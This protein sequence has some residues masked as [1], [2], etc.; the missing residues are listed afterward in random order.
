MSKFSPRPITLYTIPVPD[1]TR[2]LHVEQVALH[3]ESSAVDIGALCFLSRSPKKRAKGKGREV[4]LDSFEPAR[5][6]SIHRIAECFL[7]QSTLKEISPLTVSARCLALIQ[8][9]DWCDENGHSKALDELRFGREAF[10]G[11]AQY[12]RHLFEV[13]GRQ[14]RTIYTWQRNVIYVLNQHFDVTNIELGANAI[15]WDDRL[16][17]RTEAPTSIRFSKFVSLIQAVFTGIAELILENRPFPHAVKMPVFVGY[18]DNNMWMFPNVAGWVRHPSSDETKNAA[19]DYFRGR[20]RPVDEVAHL[21][22]SPYS[23]EASVAK[24]LSIVQMANQDMRDASRTRFASLANSIFG[25]IFEV[26]TGANRADC[27][28]IEWTEELESQIANPDS[29]RQGFRTLK[30]RANNRDVFYQIGVIYLPLLRKFLKLRAWLLNGRTYPFMIFHFTALGPAGSLGPRRIKKCDGGNLSKS[31]RLIYPQYDQIKLSNRKARA[32]KQDHVIRTYD[33]AVGAKL[34]QHSLKT[35]IKVYSNGSAESA[36]DEIGEYL[37][38]MHSTALEKGGNRTPSEEHS[39]GRCV[40]FN[41]PNSIVEVPPIRPDCKSGEGCLFCD[42]YRAHPDEKDIRK[43]LSSQ[44]VISQ[45]SQLANSA[46]EFDRIFGAVLHRIEEILTSMIDVAP[47]AKD[48]IA[49]IAQEVACGEL[50]IYWMLK[51]EELMELGLL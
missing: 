8:F 41:A 27:E 22:S 40:K 18:A 51:L 49:T 1:G 6:R 20:L 15:A 12:L 44:Y 50:D 46:E 19:Y 34:M 23:A 37:Q 5:A 21:Y 28:R 3:C 24:S 32:A 25:A 9:V 35:A 10:R 42:K 2:I 4:V 29:A 48:L 13:D 39:T 14:M 33:P 47:T 36:Q 38:K 30:V 43:L 11:Y 45:T 7:E 17:P 31:M 16:A 26:I